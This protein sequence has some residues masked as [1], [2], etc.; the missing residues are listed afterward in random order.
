MP[1]AMYLAGPFEL[2]ILL[3]GIAIVVFL[4]LKNRGK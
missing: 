2:L 1:V 4:V 3:A